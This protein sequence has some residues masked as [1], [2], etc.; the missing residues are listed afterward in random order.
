MKA[1]SHRRARWIVVSYVPLLFIVSI[2]V[3]IQEVKPENQRQVDASGDYGGEIAISYA[4]Q[5][6]IPYFK[7]AFGVDV[8]GSVLHAWY[9]GN[10]LHHSR[11][12]LI[13]MDPAT[14]SKI[15]AAIQRMDRKLDP[16]PSAFSLSPDDP[17]ALKAWWTPPTPTDKNVV[18]GVPQPPYNDAFNME[19]DSAKKLLYFQTQV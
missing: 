12:Y 14:Y 4:A 18:S 10:L 2:F 7:S 11:M 6:I 15:L 13:Q 9:A 3:F 16:Q 1:H 5:D 8:T 17:A 19:Y